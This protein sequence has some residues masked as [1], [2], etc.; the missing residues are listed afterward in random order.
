MSVKPK[1]LNELKAR[2]MDN[3]A[4]WLVSL[5]GFRRKEG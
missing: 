4:R 5:P 3:D 2:S 1:G